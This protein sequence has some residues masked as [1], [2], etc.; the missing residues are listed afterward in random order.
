M[1]NRRGRNNAKL[2]ENFFWFILL[3]ESFITLNFLEF[4]SCKKTKKFLILP[5]CRHIQQEWREKKTQD[6]FSCSHLCI[7]T[8]A[9]KQGMNCV[10]GNDDY[11]RETTFVVLIAEQRVVCDEDNAIPT[12]CNIWVNEHQLH[13]RN[14]K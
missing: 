12:Y 5:H 8:Y 14:E 3:V 7:F 11:T 2:H 4:K 9:I 6:F 10:T 13:A 1:M